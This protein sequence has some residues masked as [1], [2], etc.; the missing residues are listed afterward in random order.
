M[1]K[2]VSVKGAVYGVE[3]SSFVYGLAIRFNLRGWMCSTL[4]GVEVVVQG[5]TSSE[6]SFIRSLTTEAP[7][8]AQIDQVNVID[9]VGD[10]KY[11]TFDIR[12]SP[13]REDADQPISVDIAIC[14]DCERDLFDPRNRHYLYPFINCTHCGPRFTISKDIPY[15]RQNTSMAEFEMC[16][17]CSAE[18]NDASNRRFHAQPIACPNCGPFVALREVHSPFTSLSS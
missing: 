16:E 5:Q 3:F 18:Y 10:T 4:S 9:E 17:R 1:T 11:Q 7:P 13:Q 2:H 14:P 15:D 8:T 12:F 6:E